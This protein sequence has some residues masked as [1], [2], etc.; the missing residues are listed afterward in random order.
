M[1]LCGLHS[2]GGFS[3]AVRQCL[4]ASHV[5]NLM[6]QGKSTGPGAACKEQG[7][8]YWEWSMLMA[9]EKLNTSACFSKIEGEYK[10]VLINISIPKER[11]IGSCSFGR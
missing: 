6:M 11:P 2:P 7:Q 9:L 4:R 1:S 5:Y 8:E 10:K 3:K